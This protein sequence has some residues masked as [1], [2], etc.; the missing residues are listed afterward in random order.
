MCI[1]NELFQSSWNVMSKEGSEYERR[2]RKEKIG[3]KGPPF[4]VVFLVVAS[5][6]LSTYL[7]QSKAEKKE[8]ASSFPKL[9][10]LSL[11]SIH[12]SYL[13]TR[14]KNTCLALPSSRGCHEDR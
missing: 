5:W 2:K 12:F 3:K 8:I 11:P 7:P 4:L 13:F 6:Q 10:V 14:D 1:R 9:T